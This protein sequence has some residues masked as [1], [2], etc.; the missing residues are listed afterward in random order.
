MIMDG[1]LGAPKYVRSPQSQRPGQTKRLTD[2][3][4]YHSISV[5]SRDRASL[6]KRIFALTP[7]PGTREAN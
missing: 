3:L 1:R 5:E 4:L 2:L 6:A 7:A